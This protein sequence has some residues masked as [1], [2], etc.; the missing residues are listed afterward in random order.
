MEEN[1]DYEYAISESIKLW[2]DYSKNQQLEDNFDK[3]IIEKSPIGILSRSSQI[4]ISV[5]QNK[6]Q[7]AEYIS[8][9][10]KDMFGYNETS[11]SLLGMMLW[12][13]LVVWEHIF[14][15]IYAFR[16]HQKFMKAIPMNERINVKIFYCGLKLKNR[17]G[18]ILRLFVQ[19]N[20]LETDE[21]SEA[22][23]TLSL[24]HDIAP[25]LKNNDWWIRYSYGE[26]PQKV[27]Y[28]HSVGNKSFDHDILSER[29]IEI[30]KLI[31]EGYESKEIADK[32]FL[33]KVT[34]DTH[35]RNMIE[36]MGVIDTTAL[37]HLAKLCEMI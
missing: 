24:C 13:K 37:M 22:V 29:E 18:R 14:Y 9:N 19:T 34:I 7:K 26:K 6:T 20:P 30:L 36:R 12:M 8:P 10:V 16:I 1:P 33:S 2:L 23:R 21:E 5:F 11:D 27:K 4:V 32:L 31:A 3:S 17:W 25:Y 28:H 15:P 35:R